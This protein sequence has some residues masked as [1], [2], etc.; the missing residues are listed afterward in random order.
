MVE[1]WKHWLSLVHNSFFCLCNVVKK[2]IRRTM[3][4]STKTFTCI[5]DQ[6]VKLPT[7]YKRY[8]STWLMMMMMMGGQWRCCCCCCCRRRVVVVVVGCCWICTR[9][10]AKVVLALLL[11]YHH[12]YYKFYLYYTC[13][14]L[15]FTPTPFSSDI[16]QLRWKKHYIREAK[17]SKT[18]SH[19]FLHRP[20]LYSH[21]IRSRCTVKGNLPY[22]P[23]LDA[24]IWNSYYHF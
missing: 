22:H 24:L 15:T 12:F 14:V 8:S 10:I 17:A 13:W 3:C 4:L 7:S 23:A 20:A 19:F 18:F 21:S 5:P 2:W 9:S 16:A 1:V 6:L 11:L